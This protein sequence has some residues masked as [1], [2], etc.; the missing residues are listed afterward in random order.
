METR[1]DEPGDVGHVDPQEGADRVGD[2][3]H[4]REV[5]DPGVGGGAG[6]DQL[7][8]DLL[9]LGL[10]G[11]VVDP[12]GVL[13][14]AVAV[15]LEVAAAEVE[16]HPVGEVAAVGQAHAEDPVARI[17]GRHVRRPCWPGPRCGAG[18]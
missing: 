3:G 1:R 17:D 6:D 9:R 8:P 14:D 16:G 13:A 18:R 7:R 4:P 15:D 2:V 12:L 5:D 10:E 11:V